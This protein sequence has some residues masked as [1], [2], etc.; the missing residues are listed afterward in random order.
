MNG[1]QLVEKTVNAARAPSVARYGF[2]HAPF[3]FSACIGGRNG[4][5][6]APRDG[7]GL[8]GRLFAAILVNVPFSP[9]AAPP[10][11]FLINS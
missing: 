5:P 10:P 11:L 8:G 7:I 4:G 1:L 2:I 9:L 3:A 6:Q